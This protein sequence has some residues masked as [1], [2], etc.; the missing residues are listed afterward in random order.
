MLDKAVG[1]ES[2]DRL[3][4]ARMEG[5]PPRLREA[6]IRHVVSESVLECVLKIGKE[7]SLVEE[8]GRLEMLKAAS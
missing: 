6:P 8:L 2:L 3:H 1:V 5:T 7:A 4:D